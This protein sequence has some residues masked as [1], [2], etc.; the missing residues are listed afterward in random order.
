MCEKGVHVKISIKSGSRSEKADEKGAAHLL[1]SAAFI[2]T[3]SASGLRISRDLES[4]GVKFSATAS[5]ELVSQ[6]KSN[7][8]LQY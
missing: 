3:K 1:A 2:G 7:I 8:S 4:L 6:M 5:R